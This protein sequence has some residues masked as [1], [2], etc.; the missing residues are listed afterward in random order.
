MANMSNH[1]DQN[2]S[3]K[4]NTIVESHFFFKP[5]ALCYTQ[6]LLKWVLSECSVDE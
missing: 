2:Q 4:T 5:N 3:V 1:F 6:V